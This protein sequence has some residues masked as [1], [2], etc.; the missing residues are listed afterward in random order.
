[1]R[2]AIFTW[3]E[4]WRQ[5]PTPH[6]LLPTP[7]SLLPTPG[8]PT[9]AERKALL[10]LAALLCVG[11]GARAVASVRREPPPAE[12]RA[13]LARQIDAVDS[14]KRA[15]RG[16]RK[17]RGS[18]VGS[19]ESARRGRVRAPAAT[20]DSPFAIPNS[21]IPTPD[22]PLP[23]ID[24]DTASAPTLERLPRIGPALA[25]RIVEDRERGG[26]FGSLEGFQR[27]R[28]VGP[29]M[30]RALAEHVTFSGARRPTRAAFPPIGGAPVRGAP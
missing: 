9:P 25:R 15:G 1:M 8:L 11:A 29:A 3:A 30:A 17:G 22:S 20:R 27:V 4:V 28:G 6:S 13:A 19:G 16:G 5:L 18:G 12:A 7:H 2:R 24:V 21:P 26:A 23:T 14:A 10:Y